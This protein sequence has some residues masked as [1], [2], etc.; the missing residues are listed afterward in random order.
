M[1]LI[2][3]TQHKLPTFESQVLVFPCEV[4]QYLFRLR[5][6]LSPVERLA[7][8]RARIVRGSSAAA[9]TLSPSTVVSSASKSRRP[10][11]LSWS[12]V[13]WYNRQKIVTCFGVSRSCPQ[14]QAALVT[15]GTP[16][17]CRK[18][19]SPIFPVRSCT[20][21]E[22]SALCSPWCRL[23]TF[24][25]G[26]WGWGTAS[27]ALRGAAS[28]LSFHLAHSTLLYPF[29]LGVPAT[30]WAY[31][32]FGPSSPYRPGMAHDCGSGARLRFA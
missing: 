28:H 20:R 2:Y 13:S 19:L 26:G 15:S 21:S 22:L 27:A 3:F 8:P 6:I 17:L 10:F 29:W 23:S 32:L 12:L 1:Y 18:S 30:S 11:T 5:V 24:S 14:V 7:L 9:T 25:L 4:C 16:M 31:P